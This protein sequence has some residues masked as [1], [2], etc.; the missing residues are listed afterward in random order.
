MKNMKSDKDTT[1]KAIE[2]HV[3]PFSCN[4]NANITFFILTCLPY[5]TQAL[6]Q[7]RTERNFKRKNE[8]DEGCDMNRVKMW[9]NTFSLFPLL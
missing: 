4:C 7:S 1:K 8:E 9:C 5:P 2:R 6:V 3:S